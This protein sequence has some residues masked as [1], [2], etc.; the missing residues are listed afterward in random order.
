MT[1]YRMSDEQEA[2]YRELQA[3]FANIT[4]R[5]RAELPNKVVIDLFW[6]WNEELE[7]LI[8]E[9]SHEKK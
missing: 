5:A 8:D 6:D 2:L 7:T 4:R 3:T 9:E 1:K